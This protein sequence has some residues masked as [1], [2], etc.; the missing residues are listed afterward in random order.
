MVHSIKLDWETVFFFWIVSHDLK[1]TQVIISTHYF[2]FYLHAL[3]NFIII[4]LFQL[5][6]VADILLGRQFLKNA[7]FFSFLFFVN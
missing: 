7:I 2:K 1:E 3:N 4:I 5:F 6:T